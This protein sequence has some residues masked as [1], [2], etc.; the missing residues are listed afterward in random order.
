MTN[1]GI[2][3]N[4]DVLSCLANLSNDEVFTPPE[5]A[6]QVLD[7]LPQE[8]FQNPES[9]FL[10]PVCKTGVF[11]R[12]IAKRLTKGLEGKIPNLQERLNHI[13]SK[14]LYGIGITEMTS[15]LSRRSLYCSKYA[16]SQWSICTDFDSPT[17]NI[18]FVRNPHS[19]RYNKCLFCGGAKEMYDRGD[20]LESHAYEFIHTTKPEELFNVK[21]DVIIGNPPYQLSDGGAQAS[22]T[23][24]YQLFV[25]QAKKLNPR[26]LTMII[27]A[28][29]YSGGKWLDEFRAEMIDDKRIRQIH[30]FLNAQDCFG[31]GVE[32]KGGVCYFLWDRD[33]SGLCRVATHDRASII[34]ES[35]RYLREA[36]SDVFIRHNLGISIFHKVR[37]RKENTFDTI[38]SSRRPF[39]FTTNYVANPKIKIGIKLYQRGGIGLV[40][41]KAI[42]RNQPLVEKWKVFISKAYNAGDT[43]PHQ[44]IN[45][46]FVGEPG[47][48]C[49]ETYVV[50]GPFSN[51]NETENAISYVRTRFFRFLV[52]LKKISQDATSKVYSFVPIQDFSR[53]WTD[54]ELYGKY[55]LTYDEI[56]FVESMIRPM[57][58]DDGDDNE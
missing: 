31:T 53:P 36:G 37:S 51:K 5:L 54:Q 14:Q 45:K 44:I 10:D 47:S 15:L 18:R 48:C 46:P 2:N 50:I 19:W 34:S 42:L 27:P 20:L 28:R 16:N 17:G 55:G 52:F 33:N 29:W 30:D 43:Y 11:L 22:A 21:F 57:N 56:S 6:N 39:G 4:P 9:R 1:T 3:Y 25:K 58:I 24:I 8:L 7:M 26:Y 35:E 32:I 40:E 49:T 23:P 12:E 41:K 13:F 38:V